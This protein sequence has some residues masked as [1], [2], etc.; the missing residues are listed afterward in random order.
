[1]FKKTVFIALLAFLLFSY[2]CGQSKKPPAAIKIGKADISANEFDT[3]FKNSSFSTADTPASRKDFLDNFIMRRLIVLEAKDAGLDKDPEFMKNAEFFWQQSLVKMMVDKKIK[4]LSS[5]IRVNDSDV[6][7]YYEIYKDAEFTGA[8]LAQVYDRIK[9]IILNKKQKEA[10]D[11]WLNS[12]KS[13]SKVNINYK[14]L[15]IDK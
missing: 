5:K 7:N 13:K 15:K 1:M 9:W 10:M 2:G 12:L 11:M 4:E 8:P 14:L 6:K 3:A